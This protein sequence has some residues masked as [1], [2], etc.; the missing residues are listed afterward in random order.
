MTVVVMQSW[1]LVVL[2]AFSHSQPTFANSAS[3]DFS[4]LVFLFSFSEII[5]DW[6]LENSAFA[7]CISSPNFSLI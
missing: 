4:F 7:L 1:W 6:S 2:D 5:F 3:F